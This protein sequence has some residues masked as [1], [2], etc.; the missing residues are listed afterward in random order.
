[1]LN[2]FDGM[3]PEEMME[4]AELLENPLK[5]LE[6]ETKAKEAREQEAARKKKAE[7]DKRAAALAAAKKRAAEEASVLAL[8][9]AK[10]R[11]EQGRKIVALE[12]DLA[13]CKGEH[14][15]VM[16]AEDKLSRCESERSDLDKTHLQIDAR[17]KPIFGTRSFEVVMVPAL[18][19]FC[20]LFFLLGCCVTNS[21]VTPFVNPTAGTSGVSIS[22]VIIRPGAEVCV[23]KNRSFSDVVRSR[24]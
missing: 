17:I 22:D 9:K 19:V 11:D 20:V 12:S 21:T 2:D 7:E 6:E 14:E 13:T 10:E 24:C 15:G 5:Q 8:Q 3:S 23:I 16:V 4:C 1:M 18:L